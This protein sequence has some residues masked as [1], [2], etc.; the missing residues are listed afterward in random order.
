MSSIYLLG[1]D[2]GFASLGYAV[3]KLA[4]DISDDRVE[5]MGT[6]ITEKSNKKRS[7]YASDDNLRR[8][9]EIRSALKKVVSDAALKA[10]VETGY[11]GRV[12]GI[13]AEAMS[14][15][16]NAGS[17]AKVAMAWGII[18][19]M[20]LPVFQMSPQAIKLAVCGTKSASKSDVEEG[21]IS[22][23]RGKTGQNIELLLKDLPKSK[24]EHPY[25]ALA[26]I[27]ACRDTEAVSLIRSSICVGSTSP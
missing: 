7:V 18:A 4:P 1:L 3:L 25:D 9:K 10:K 21:L 16:R 2:P 12:V 19:S 24:R 8:A 13:C 6:I 27:V 23:F 15:P 26:A 5:Y 14:F 22:M 20:D 17:A 11:E